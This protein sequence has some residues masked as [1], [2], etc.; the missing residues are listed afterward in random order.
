MTGVFFASLLALPA[1]ECFMRLPFLPRLHTLIAVVKKSANVVM[2]R[3]IS[4]HWKEIVLVRYARD[5]ALHTIILALMLTGLATIVVLPA[6]ML[7]YL[8]APVPSTVQSLYSP[9][10]LTG[11]TLVSAVYLYA[12]KRVGKPGL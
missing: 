9:A 8:V 5:M 12:R 6:L 7:D 10:G 3:N 4:D 2:A 1:I 11:M